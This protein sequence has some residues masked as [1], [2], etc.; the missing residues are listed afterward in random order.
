MSIESDTSLPAGFAELEPFVVEWAV[1]RSSERASKRWASDMDEING[2][3]VA[4][5]S[6]L[7]SALDHLDAFDLD[8]MPERERRLF[9]LTL[10]LAEIAGAVE[11]YGQPRVPYAFSPERYMPTES[12]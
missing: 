2:F 10:S 12:G 5:L 3:Y 7:E 4:M 6:H 11:V 8:T 9:H 1:A